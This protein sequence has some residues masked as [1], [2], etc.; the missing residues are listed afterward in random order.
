MIKILL[1]TAAIVML[2]SCTKYPL[3]VNKN[4]TGPDTEI[5]STQSQSHP[6]PTVTYPFSFEA[7]GPFSISPVSP[8]IVSIEQQM[9]F[10]SS[11]PF[12]L[13]GGYVRGFDDLRIPTFPERFFDGSLRFSGKG[14]DSIFGIVTVQTSIFSDPIDPEAGDFFGSEDFTGTFRITGGTGRYIHAHG[15][16][17]YTAHS[18]WRP[19]VAAGTFFSGSTSVTGTGIISVVARNGQLQTLN[20]KTY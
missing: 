18:E 10:S 13:R 2:I 3:E 20:A 16:G 19:P 4:Q 11:S 15:S 5:S 14:N 9:S 8:V 1:I 12:E 6:D 7:T 17:E